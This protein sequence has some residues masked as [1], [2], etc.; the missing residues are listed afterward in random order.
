MQAR[1]G[2]QICP[3]GVCLLCAERAWRIERCLI[4]LFRFSTPFSPCSSFVLSPFLFVHHTFPLLGQQEGGFVSM[5]ISRNHLQGGSSSGDSS[6]LSSNNPYRDLEAQQHPNLVNDATPIQQPPPSSSRP[7]NAFMTFAIRERPR[8]DVSVVRRNTIAT[9]PVPI[10]EFDAL[11]DEQQQPLYRRPSRAESIASL[12]A[13]SQ[14]DSNEEQD[15]SDTARLTANMAGDDPSPTPPQQPRRNQSLRKVATVLRRVSRRVV[16]NNTMATIDEQPM[17]QESIPMTSTSKDTPSSPPPPPPPP[18]TQIMPLVQRQ[19][20]S[21]AIILA[22]KS[23]GIFGP[24]NPLRRMF[25][26]ML[27]WR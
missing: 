17:I 25:A 5:S 15:Y 23:L 3:L 24:E 6:R 27:Q 4:F 9:N 19:R 22:G 7:P 10:E 18:T 21:R 2:N 13:H 14:Y 12:A 16:N 20:K 11:F 1:K 8:P 26:K